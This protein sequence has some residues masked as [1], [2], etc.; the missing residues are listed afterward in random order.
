MDSERITFPDG[1]WWEIKSW[2]TRG[3]RRKIDQHVLHQ[4]FAMLGVLKAEGVTTED[5]QAMRERIPDVNGRGKAPN[6]DEDDA[7]LLYGTT[8]WVWPEP[9]SMET[10][11]NRRED[12]AAI[13]LR[14]MRELYQKS[15]EQVKN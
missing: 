8:A 2:L 6:I 11:Q 1:N 12:S 9:I 15:E 10:V 13:V 3:D 7:L 4:G 5:V 14:R